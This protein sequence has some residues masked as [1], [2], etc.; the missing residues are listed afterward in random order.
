LRESIMET[1]VAVGCTVVNGIVAVDGAVATGVI[2]MNSAVAPTD[3]C[4]F[5]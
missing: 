2:A 3:S 1:A 4:A 5:C